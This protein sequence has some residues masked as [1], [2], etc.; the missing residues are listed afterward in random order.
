MDL[1]QLSPVW[2]EL[3]LAL[4]AMALLMLGAFSRDGEQAGR[5]TGWLAIGVLLLWAA[6]WG[7]LTL[8]AFGTVGT[9]VWLSAGS[10]SLAFP[11]GVILE[12]LLGLDACRM[13]KASPA[14]RRSF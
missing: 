5:L 12:S 6:F 11:I 9:L 1:S 7:A 4:G 14:M 2:P 3:I 13:L 8:W 10:V